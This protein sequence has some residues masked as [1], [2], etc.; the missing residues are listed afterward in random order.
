ML[1]RYIDGAKR[2]IADD[3][4]VQLESDFVP[5]AEDPVRI[6]DTIWYVFQRITYIDNGVKMIEVI[7]FPPHVCTAPRKR[8]S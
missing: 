2:G 8:K 1:V 6:G 3:V 5:N 7:L 4:L